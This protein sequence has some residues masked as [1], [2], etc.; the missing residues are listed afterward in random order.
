MQLFWA[1]YLVAEFGIELTSSVRQFSFFFGLTFWRKASET[2]ENYH[3]N[4][5][6]CERLS[7]FAD[8]DRDGQ[9]KCMSLNLLALPL[10][11]T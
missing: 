8:R 7:L 4:A 1:W 6:L 3:K 10:T 2:Q 11:P 9:I 5:Q